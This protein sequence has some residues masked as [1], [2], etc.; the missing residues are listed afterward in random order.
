MPSPHRKQQSMV[1][2]TVFAIDRNFNCSKTK[3]RRVYM[4]VKKKEKQIHEHKIGYMHVY[5]V[6]DLSKIYMSMY[7]KICK[8]KFELNNAWQIHLIHVWI[9]FPSIFYFREY[10][11]HTLLVYKEV[12]YLIFFNAHVYKEI[13]L[14]NKENTKQETTLNIHTI[15]TQIYAPE[16]SDQKSHLYPCMH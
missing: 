7:S 8:N 12:R 5:N 11:A 2:I 16:N 10:I 13:Y 6:Q 15:W 3:L 4:K 1:N 9:C 14:L